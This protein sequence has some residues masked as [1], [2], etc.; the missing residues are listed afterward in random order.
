MAVLALG[1]LTGSHLIAPGSVL[2][3]GCGACDDVDGYELALGYDP[4]NAF[5]TPPAPNGKG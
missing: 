2:A 3:G 1:A 5:S 4:L